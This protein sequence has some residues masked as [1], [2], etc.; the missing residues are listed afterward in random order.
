MVRSMYRA[1]T[2]VPIAF[3]DTPSACVAH[4]LGN[5]R[6][7]VDKKCHGAMRFKLVQDSVAG[8]VRCLNLGRGRLAPVL[9]WQLINKLPPAALLDRC[10]AMPMA[11]EPSIGHPLV[12]TTC[13]PAQP[14]C[15]HARRGTFTEPASPRSCQGR[16]WTL[17]CGGKIRIDRREGTLG[18]PQLG[19]A[20]QPVQQV[21]PTLVTLDGGVQPERR[22]QF[23][24]R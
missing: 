24:A 12:H 14:V 3:F 13:R 11:I 6:Y 10:L 2:I 22:L 15:T 7:G 21:T 5:C 17:A 16:R 20:Q 8:K 1:C 23:D 18:L 9:G 4:D 19:P